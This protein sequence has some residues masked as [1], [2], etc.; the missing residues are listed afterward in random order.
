MLAAMLRNV[1]QVVLEDVP[2]PGPGPTRV[3]VRMRAT[4][5][6]ASENMLS[7]GF[8]EYMVTEE[9]NVYHKPKQIAS[10]AAA[11]RTHVRATSLAFPFG[12]GWLRPSCSA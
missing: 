11:S 6:D 4:G 1:N 12:C 5:G 9:N 2:K 8:A 10:P 7:G 3:A